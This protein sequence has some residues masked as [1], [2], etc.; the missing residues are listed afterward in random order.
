MGW[1]S[2]IRSPT[3]R[4]RQGQSLFII[5]TRWRTTLLSGKPKREITRIQLNT[6]HGNY[7]R[8]LVL[9]FHTATLIVGL[10]ECE[11]NPENTFTHE[12]STIFP[13]PLTLYIRMALGVGEATHNSY[14]MA[15]FVTRLTMMF[16]LLLDYTRVFH[17]LAHTTSRFICLSYINLHFQIQLNSA[18]YFCFQSWT[19]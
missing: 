11:R 18:V 14:G 19:L 17:L 8:R 2:G 6:C 4:R 3:T 12:Q 15:S 9:T 7:H 13:I 5:S 1:V 10:C 16:D